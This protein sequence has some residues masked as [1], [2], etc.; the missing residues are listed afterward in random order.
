MVSLQ[1]W[2]H[3]HP[4]FESS[5]SCIVA[6]LCVSVAKMRE[7]GPKDLPRVQPAVNELQV[8]QLGASIGQSQ[9]FRSNLQEYAPVILPQFGITVARG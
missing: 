8:P 4:S 7:R 6:T 9:T 5:D 2:S 1:A 3:S